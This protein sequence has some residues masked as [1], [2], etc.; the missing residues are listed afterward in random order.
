MIHDVRVETLYIVCNCGSLHKI[1]GG[2]DAPV[3]WCR[4]ELCELK[5]GDI[6]VVPHREREPILLYMN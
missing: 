1:G 4:D 6:V 3:Y 5:E 2:L